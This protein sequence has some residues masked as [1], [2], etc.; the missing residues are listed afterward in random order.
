[1]LANVLNS[2]RAVQVSIQIVRTFVRL[3]EMLAS[4][5]WTGR[6]SLPVE[7]E[8]IPGGQHC[9]QGHAVPNAIGN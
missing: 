6:T 1:M 2:P 5:I 9:V 7:S 4:N 8:I 3:R